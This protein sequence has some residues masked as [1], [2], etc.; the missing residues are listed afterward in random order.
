LESRADGLRRGEVVPIA[1]LDDD[2][3]GTDI[4]SKEAKISSGELAIGVA[5]VGDLRSN[6]AIEADV[7]IGDMSDIIHKALEGSSVLRQDD[8][9][10]LNLADLLGDDALRELS[11]NSKSLLDQSDVFSLTDYDIA[12]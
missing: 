6:R 1:A 12:L 9:L 5:K 10:N 8:C 4:V 7:A 3:V 11:K 2:R